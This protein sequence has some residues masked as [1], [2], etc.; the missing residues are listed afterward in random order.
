M[1]SSGCCLCR[2][3]SCIQIVQ[4]AACAM[5]LVC[6]GRPEEPWLSTQEPEVQVL[7]EPFTPCSLPSLGTPP[8]LAEAT[9]GFDIL[10]LG[11][12]CPLTSPACQPSQGQACRPPCPSVGGMAVSAGR[13]QPLL[14]QGLCPCCSLSPLSSVSSRQ[15]IRLQLEDRLP[16]GSLLTL[17]RPPPSHSPSALSSLLSF[18]LSRRSQEQ[19]LHLGH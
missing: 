5:V 14:P 19:K 8:H 17:A 13:C 7:W 11:P 18:W 15:P 6:V 10:T 12:L 16:R 9:L 3:W 4:F 2:G 1:P